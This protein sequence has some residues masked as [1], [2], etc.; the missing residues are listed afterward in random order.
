MIKKYK[1]NKATY[2]R[3][4]YYCDGKFTY[5][6]GDVDRGYFG[7]TIKCPY[8]EKTNKAT[9]RRFWFKF[10]KY[11]KI[12]DNK[13]KYEKIINDKNKVIENKDKEISNIKCDYEHDIK[14]EKESKEQ[15][16]LELFAVKKEN[17]KLSHLKDDIKSKITP[18]LRDIQYRKGV[19]SKKMVVDYLQSLVDYIDKRND[20]NDKNT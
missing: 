9:Y 15:L 16:K 20:N 12:I 3:K 10:R 18:V 6:F 8:C 17:K 14:L 19:I 2:I 11:E 4:C 13:E 5:Q 1:E 7:D